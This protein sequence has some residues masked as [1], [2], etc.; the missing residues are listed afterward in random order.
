MNRY[1]TQI[2]GHQFAITGHTW[3]P[4]REL[5]QLIRKR[6]GSVPGS[7]DVSG[8]TTVLIKGVSGVWA[9]GDHGTK[10]SDAA[11]L[12]RTGHEVLIV[13]DQDF[14][15]LVT[16][17]LRA[18]ALD[19]VAGVPIEWLSPPTERNFKKIASISGPLD[20]QHTAKGRVEQGYLRARLL[21]GKLDGECALC[22]RTLPS[23]LLI[24]AH[25]KPRAECTRKE[26][27]DVDHIV[28]P[29]CLLGCDALYE[30]GLV[31]VGEEGEI[32]A[33]TAYGHSQ[34]GRI[35][36]GL[37]GKTCTAWRKENEAYFAW[38]LMERYQG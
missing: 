24:A 18:K 12:I 11:E 16:K 10:E 22:H 4:R 30:K 27:L 29:T 23:S 21:K 17:G 37:K 20:R 13:N 33:T 14:K 32:L 38:H 26:R 1:L 8:K 28:F 9:Y 15:K 2:K 19:Y 31:A 3:L 35:L 5:M 6:G 36:N 7:C 25:I 34:L